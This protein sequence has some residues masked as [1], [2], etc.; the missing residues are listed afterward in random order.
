MQW[1]IFVAGLVGAGG[2][3]GAT[4]YAHVQPIPAL[5]QAAYIALFHAPVLLWLSRERQSLLKTLLSVGFILGVSLFTG[6]IYLRY[7]VGVERATIVAPTGGTLLIV[8]W[9]G[10]SGLALRS[11]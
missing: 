4:L 3:V 6:S 11:R 2:L 7:L 5:E 10:I 8:S 9:L 1:Q